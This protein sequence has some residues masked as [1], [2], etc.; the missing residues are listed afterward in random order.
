MT[1]MLTLP[2]PDAVPA[3]CSVCGTAIYVTL[4]QRIPAGCDPAA[5]AP[6]CTRCI[7]ADPDLRKLASPQVV[8]SAIRVHQIA[9]RRG[10]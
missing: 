7:V 6:V 3:A 10:N 8:A 1:D 2:H 9:D 4:T 5:V